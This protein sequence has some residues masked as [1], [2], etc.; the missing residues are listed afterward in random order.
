MCRALC[1]VVTSMQRKSG[2]CHGLEELERV[3]PTLERLQDL[4]PADVALSLC[5]TT[6]VWP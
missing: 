1:Y 2:F 6:C 4:Q 3:G 5:S